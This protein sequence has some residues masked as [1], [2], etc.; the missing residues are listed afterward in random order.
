MYNQSSS[1]RDLASPRSI[2]ILRIAVA[3]CFIGHGAFGIITK[4]AWVPYFGVAHISEAWAWK[5]MPWVGSM[6]IVLGLTALLWRRPSRWLWA[7][8]TTWAVWTA[9]LRPFSG[10]SVWEAVE[11]AGNYSVPLALFLLAVGVRGTR[12]ARVLRVGAALLLCGHGMLALGGKAALVT[13]WHAILP[14]LDALTMTRAAGAVELAMAFFILLEPTATLC[15][16]ACAWKLAT[17]SLFF[18]VGAP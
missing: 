17:E 18:V 9:L 8:M 6:D 15:F 12:V 7:W 11:R 14:Q 2:L 5:L 3:M 4:K 10:E 13:H 1:H 16:T